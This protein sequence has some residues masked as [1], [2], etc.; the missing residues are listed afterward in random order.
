VGNAM[1]DAALPL[2]RRGGRIVVSGQVADY[3]TSPER[4]HG[5]RN[6]RFFIA[7]RLRMEGLVVFD[8]L[9]DFPAAQEQLSALVESGDIKVREVR[10]RGLESAPRAFIDLFED[11]A[12][13][14]RRIIEIGGES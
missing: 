6:T 14:G 1:I 13:F 9:R 7:N 10:Y 4:V 11:A 3:N 8:D 2:M 5:L 12:T